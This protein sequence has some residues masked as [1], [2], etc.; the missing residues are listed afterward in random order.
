MRASWVH[1]WGKL[2]STLGSEGKWYINGCIGFYWPMW[3]CLCG[4]LGWRKMKVWG[5]MLLLPSWAPFLPC[6]WSSQGGCIFIQRNHPPGFP[7]MQHQLLKDWEEV[8]RA[9]PGQDLNE[10]GLSEG[11]RPHRRL[12]RVAL[13]PTELPVLYSLLSP[14]PLGQ[15]SAK[16]SPFFLLYIYTYSHTAFTSLSL[17]NSS[18]FFPPSLII[19][20]LS[21][22]KLVDHDAV[23]INSH[24][25]RRWY[26]W[27]SASDDFTSATFCHQKPISSLGNCGYMASETKASQVLSG[28]KSFL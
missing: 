27:F 18:Y 17:K 21:Q 8:H 13:C 5:L 28:F 19:P 23:L 6:K 15:P 9:H 22:G 24:S 10:T 1:S 11:S 7:W 20:R 12:F 16:I 3:V 25:F 2:L 4:V 26:D 14:D